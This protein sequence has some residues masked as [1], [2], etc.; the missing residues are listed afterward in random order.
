MSVHMFRV[1]VGIG[2]MSQSDLETAVND[3]IDSHTK[4]EDGTAQTSVE[5]R[6]TEPDGS[7]VDFH[8][9]SIRLEKT[10]T[11]AN[12]LQKLTDKIKD[13]VDWY[14]VP[15]HQC[16]RQVSGSDGDCSWEQEDEWTAKDVTIPS[17]IPGPHV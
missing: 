15:Y 3:W 14:R 16:D 8:Y 5:K 4:F 7:G 17:E 2:S 6:N 10:D 9:C 11:K 12:I 1:Y 13:K